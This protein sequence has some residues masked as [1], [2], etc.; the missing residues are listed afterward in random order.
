MQEIYDFLQRFLRFVLSRY[1]LKCNAGLFF[2]IHLGIAL[3]NTHH[4][5]TLR[6]PLEAPVEHRHDQY[7]RQEGRNHIQYHHRSRI[8]YLLFIFNTCLV[9]SF[10]KGIIIHNS[11]IIFLRCSLAFFL[12]GLDH[13]LVTGNRNFLHLV[14]LDHV[15][16]LVIRD[17]FC[18]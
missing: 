3:A 15:Q 12:L 8:R 17:L 14:M 13:D 2:Y 6:H 5:S 7:D 18:R 10:G 9:Q 1:I 4:A 11:G 16:K